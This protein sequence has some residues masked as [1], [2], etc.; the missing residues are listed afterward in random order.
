LTFAYI[1]PS[2]VEFYVTYAD[3]SAVPTS[4]YNINVVD[5]GI[6][7]VTI[8]LN[9]TISKDIR[10]FF[11]KYNDPSYIKMEKLDII[12]TICGPQNAQL[13]LDEL[14]EYCNSVDVAFVRKSIKCVGQIAVKIE[15]AA[16]RCVDI[17]VSLVSGK[18]DYAIEESIIVVCDILRKF[19]GNFESILSKVCP[20]IEQLKESR[21]K[22]AGI[23]LLGEYCSIIENVDVLLDPFLYTFQDETPQVQLQILSSLVKVYIEKPDETRDQLQFVLNEAT[24]DSN[25]PD[26]KNRALIY[27]RILSA[28]PQVAK[29]IVVFSKETVMHSGVHFDD[30]ILEELIKNMGTVSGVLHIVPSDFVSRIRYVPEDDDDITTDN[31]NLRIW[32]QLKLNNDSFVDLF[33]DFDKNNMYLR[34]A[35][36]SPSPIGQFAFAINQNP[37]GLTIKSPP[38]FPETLEFG[39]VAEVVIPIEI[40]SSKSGNFENSELQMALR[41]SLGNVYALGRLPI[42]YAPISSGNI[43]ADEFRNDFSSFTNIIQI[44]IDDANLANDNQLIERNLFIIGKNDSKVYISFKLS[45]NSIFVA[46]AQQVGQNIQITVKIIFNIRFHTLIRLT[47]H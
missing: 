37:I 47:S 31:S 13:V 2:K 22:A 29:D 8:S 16:R 35:N 40:D 3:G 28:D 10:V 6:P 9:T 26:V 18:A 17:L 14:N 24:K 38:S 30:T 19:P 20:S 41:T 12:V 25:V 11:C 4:I 1:D 36:K 15:A 39:D 7:S 33:S 45:E 5:H 43:S 46:E 32:R 27:W 44:Q 23:W 34:I 42:E 21:A